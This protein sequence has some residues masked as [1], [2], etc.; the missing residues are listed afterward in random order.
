MSDS[1]LLTSAV[2]SYLYD[3]MLLCLMEEPS[4]ELDQV[5]PIVW[6]RQ[7]NDWRYT[8]PS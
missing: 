3:Y 4:I 7:L 6:P 5:I 8:L 1:I 2:I